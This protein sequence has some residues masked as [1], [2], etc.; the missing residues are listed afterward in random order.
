MVAQQTAWMNSEEGIELF[1][2]A[3]A[4]YS[5][6]G[7]ENTNA[8]ALKEAG[9][10]AITDD[11]LPVMDD[12]VMRRPK[13]CRAHDLLF[14]QHAEDIEM[15]Q[16]APMNLSE[17]SEAL[18]VR[19]Q[20]AEAEARIVERDIELVK[21]T[22]ARYHVL[23]TSTER[24]LNAVREAKRQGLPVSCEV[25]PHHILLNDTACANGDP[26]TKMNPPLRD[27]ED[28]LA[29]IKGL[30][31]G[32]VDAV[33]TDH[34]P[35]SEEEKAQGFERAPF[36]VIGLETAFAAVL[37]FV[38]NGTISPSRAVELM[39]SGPARVLKR[40]NHLGSLVG[41]QQAAHACIVDP[42][43]DWCATRDTFQGKSKN[44]AFLNR[45]FKGK[46]VQTYVNGILKY[47]H[48]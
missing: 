1:V 15:T 26:N 19:G 20:A 3:A 17:T 46:V 18:G 34:A 11:G 24:S 13:D 42:E 37:H 16:H 41:E 47:Q 32:T 25:S 2:A 38:H 27:E 21:T 44:S 31:D 14:M 36:G 33:A 30:A 48:N 45:N 22:G 7:K 9:A 35:H 4:T 29:L 10:I 8:G 23:H 28:R 43:L 6:A 39:T 5:L 12:D 40:E